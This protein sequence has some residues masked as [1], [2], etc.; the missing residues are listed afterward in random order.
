MSNHKDLSR[1]FTVIR[2]K[3]DKEIS[4]IGKVIEGV[5]FPDGRVV[6]QWQTDRSSIAMFSNLED[7]QMV[8]VKPI[9]KENEFIWHDGYEPTHEI[10]LACNQLVDFVNA[11]TGGRISD[12]TKG[13]LIGKIMA[14]RNSAQKKRNGGLS[15]SSLRN[16]ERNQRRSEP[17]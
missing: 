13:D 5:V 6:V 16:I 3:D 11:Y 2:H 17:A 1:L 10:D 4:G 8:H 7:F 15:P 9:F 12:K 14:I